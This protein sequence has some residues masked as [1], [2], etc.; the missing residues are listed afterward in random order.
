MITNDICQEFRL[1]QLV[2]GHKIYTWNLINFRVVMCIEFKIS[3]F[4][5][6]ISPRAAFFFLLKKVL[7]F[8][9]KRVHSTQA[10]TYVSFKFLLVYL[11]ALILLP[12]SWSEMLWRKNI[13]LN[14]TKLLR[15][16]TNLFS[17]YKI[18]SN[19][20]NSY[21]IAVADV[22]CTRWHRFFPFFFTVAF[23]AFAFLIFATTK[24]PPRAIYSLS[25]LLCVWARTKST[26][27]LLVLY[28]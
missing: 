9:N 5:P 28:T 22:C 23:F 21:K 20:V 27:I 11:S 4:I 26:F 7:F 2:C 16:I 13:S 6:L 25:C 15:S 19:H 8:V 17:C 24:R 18:W 3:R 1:L 10:K 14:K 12:Y